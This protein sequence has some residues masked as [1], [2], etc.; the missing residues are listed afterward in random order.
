[1]STIVHRGKDK[2]GPQDQNTEPLAI[3]G[4]VPPHDLDAEACVLSAIML[5]KDALDHVVDILKPQHFYSDANKA[6]MEAALA[7]TEDGTPVDIQTV[8]SWL[9]SR[10]RIGK[11]GGPGYLVQLVDATPSVANVSAY[12]M[13]VFELWRLRQLIGRC[14]RIAA[15]GYGDVGTIQD[16]IDQAEH[17]IYMLARVK[18]D[19]S[20]VTIKTAITEVFQQITDAAARGSR[21]TGTPTGYERLDAK[22]AGLHKGD[23]TIVAAR[24]GMGKTAFVLNLAVNVAS[25][26]E[27]SIKGSDGTLV[28]QVVPGFGVA[29]FSLEMPRE[30][31]ASRMVCTEGGVDLGMVR[32]G[33]IDVPA[34]RRLTDAANK[35]SKLP[36]W[37]DDTPALSI[38]ELRAKARRIQAEYK[39]QSV[40]GQPETEVGLIIVDYLQLMRGSETAN[41][42]E[43]EISEISRGLKQLAKELKVPVIALS[44]LNRAVEQRQDKR[45]GLADL[46]ESGA[47]EQDADM[48]LFIYRDE[49]YNPKSDRKGIAEIIIGKQ[50][51]GPTGKILVRFTDSYTRFSNLAP[52]DYD[53]AAEDE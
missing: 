9:R 19:A 30:Q 7:L 46:R 42:R 45:P 14:Q 6:I 2:F 34:W 32:Q 12:A 53:V 33:M 11:V 47:I 4:R 24:P 1:M 41:G 15:E 44:Q 51:N 31:L 3:A 38:L 27:E 25:P 22:T 5:E 52:A 23:L 8:A 21:I 20:S 39:R 10:E 28:R 49:Y 26:R 36:I 50:R 48:I 43:Q 17:Q 18:N 40:Q 37:V 35:L 29:V 16:F 13:I